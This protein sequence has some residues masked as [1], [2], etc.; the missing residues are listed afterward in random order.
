MADHPPVQ[1][2]SPLAE[3]SPTSLDELFSRD[4][5]DLTDN[6]I[7]KIVNELRAKR[8]LWLDAEA[9]GAKKAPK[10]AKKAVDTTGKSAD[11]LLKEIGL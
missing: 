9:Q 7:E 11:D 6:D 1:A 3:A 4:P 2:N 5:L 8:A 10:A